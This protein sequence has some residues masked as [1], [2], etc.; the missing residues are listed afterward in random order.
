MSLLLVRQTKA[1][2]GEI[3]IVNEKVAFNSNIVRLLSE[4][5]FDGYLLFTKTW[6]DRGSAIW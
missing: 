2:I 5:F 3:S 4:M 1:K 6:I